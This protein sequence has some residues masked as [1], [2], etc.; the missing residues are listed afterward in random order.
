MIRPDLHR[1]PGAD[2]CRARSADAVWRAVLPVDDV[3]GTIGLAFDTGSTTIRLR[4]SWRDA[5]AAATDLLAF[6][7][8]YRRRTNGHSDTSRGS[9]QRDVSSPFEGEKVCPPA[10]SSA[11]ATGE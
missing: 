2:A 1:L 5:E 8:A 7:E 4:I 11:A 10:R 6:V 9:P 3:D